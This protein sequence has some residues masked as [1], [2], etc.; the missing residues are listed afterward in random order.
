MRRLALVL[1]ALAAAVWAAPAQAD[2]WCGTT[3]PRDRP[4]Q[5]VAGP[6]VHVVYAHPSDA[7]DRSAELGQSIHDDVTAIDAWWRGQDPARTPRFDLFPFACG[8]QVDLSAV[9]LAQTSAALA[10]SD[11]RG[12]L[13]VDGL[14][15]GG[16]GSPFSKYVVYV[17]GPTDDADLCGQGGGDLREGPAYALVYLSACDGVPR[18]GVA[19][20]ELL[21]AFGA[22]GLG[23]PGACPD[24]DGHPCDSELDILYP[25]ASETPLAQLLLD[26]NRDDYYGH[27]ASHVDVR[28]SP[29]LRT[30]DAQVALS[31]AVAG[32]GTVRS[33][34]PGV[35]CS[36]TCTT[37]WDRGAAAALEAQP[38]AG[39][40]FIRWSGACTGVA[41][42]ALGLAAPRSVRALFAP[43]R[44]RLA[45][46]VAGRGRIASRPAGLS[47]PTR[48]A[49]SFTSYEPLRLTATAARGWRFARWT[50][51]CAASRRPACTLPMRAATSARAVFV[52]R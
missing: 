48:C 4:Q 27:G 44:F 40:R 33:D 37:Q 24:D 25:F 14:F 7:P 45:V 41:T 21:H 15:A 10:A 52:R 2:P 18:A 26:V 22:V 8:P 35:L 51:A 46:S 28:L 32:R 50:G 1:A 16:F 3:A 5:A 12:D 23:A 49:A 47:C 39:Q 6:P 42:C 13:V 38:A 34:V 29:W 36:A 19:A 11:T 30:L 31:V 17:D 9:R 20:H 43:A